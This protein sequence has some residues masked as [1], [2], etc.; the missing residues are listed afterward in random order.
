MIVRDSETGSVTHRGA[1]GQHEVASSLAD[2]AMYR[3]LHSLALSIHQLKNGAIAA[4]QAGNLPLA[5]QHLV[6]LQTM[7]GYFQQAAAQFRTSAPTTFTLLERV[8]LP[9]GDWTHAAVNALPG[10][11]S[12]LPKA[13][14]DAVAD[15][16]RHTGRKAGAVL[17]PPLLV[18]GVVALGV[19]ALAGRAE[20]TRTYRRYVA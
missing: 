14:V 4:Q 6:G 10:A 8:L 19:I 3:R 5:R 13:L 17:F 20:R 11:L 2:Q 16:V 15:L 9:L 1:L 18:L 12:V 7:T